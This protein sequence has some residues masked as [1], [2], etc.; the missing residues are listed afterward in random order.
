MPGR[1]PWVVL[2]VPE[3]ARYQEVQR[4]FRRMVK[5]THPDG[6]GD[7]RAFDAVVRAF[8]DIRRTLPWETVPSPTRL[9]ASTP[10]DSWIC[11][12]RP[13]R[14][15]TDDGGTGYGAVTEPTT[16]GADAPVTSGA[17]DFT[18]M[19]RDEMAKV[20]DLVGV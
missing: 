6:G 20:R 15:W 4:S 11:P 13:A 7:A 9:D 10:Y 16:R 1:N 17:S 19:L 2:C 12:S 14:S 5:T 8:E 3:D 18:A